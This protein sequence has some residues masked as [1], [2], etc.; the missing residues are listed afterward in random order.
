MAIFGQD[1]IFFDLLEKQANCAREVARQFS[2]MTSDIGQSA[3]LAI[4]LKKLE[5]QADDVTHELT[6]KVDA[7]FITPYDKEDLHDL[8][9]ALDDIVDLIEAAASRVVLFRL[10]VPQ[11]GFAEL[12]QLLEQ[13]VEATSKAV[14]GLRNL[15]DKKK[16]H[17]LTTRIHELENEHDQIF[18]E[19][20]GT[21]F[22]TPSIE[23]IL[24][25]KWK[26]V[27][28]RME[29][30]ADTCER[31]AVILERLQVKYA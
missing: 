26:E 22:N 20:I 6:N 7:R 4:E 31:V 15:K 16:L 29:L 28:D 21:L 23:P 30:A 12:G 13:T 24:A 11:S 25:I 27:F 3:V 19:A 5:E 9:G 17:D 1:T 2:V 8:A 18:R 14:Y 10:E